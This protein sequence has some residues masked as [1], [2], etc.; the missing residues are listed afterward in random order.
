MES[1]IREPNIMAAMTGHLQYVL[2]MQESHDENVAA[3]P[4]ASFM[5]SD[6]VQALIIWPPTRQRKDS[7][8]IAVNRLVC[9]LV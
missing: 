7:M 4:F 5:I 9:D 1:T 3:T 6:M 8:L 2:L